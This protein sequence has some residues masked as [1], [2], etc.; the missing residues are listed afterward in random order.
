MIIFAEAALETRRASEKA[1]FTVCIISGAATFIHK[2]TKAG[3]SYSTEHRGLSQYQGPAQGVSIRT[4]SRTENRKGWRTFK[5]GCG[6]ADT[7][8]RVERVTG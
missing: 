3:G 8:L 1:A 6:R 2:E 4:S 7:W 5:Y